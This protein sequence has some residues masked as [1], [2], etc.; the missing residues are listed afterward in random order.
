MNANFSEV[1]E[2]YKELKKPQLKPGS[3]ASLLKL[4]TKIDKYQSKKG[5]LYLQN[6]S[7]EW[8]VVFMKEL[9]N[10]KLGRCTNK[11]LKLYGTL[12]CGFLKHAKMFGYSINNDFDQILRYYQNIKTPKNDKA[13]LKDEELAALYKYK[14]YQLKN[15]AFIKITPA[16]QFGIHLFVFQSQIGFRWGYLARLQRRH[17]QK[18]GNNW[19]IVD[20][21]TQKRGK[22]VSVHLNDLAISILRVYR[23]AFEELSGKTYLFQGSKNC[24][25]PSCGNATHNLK[26]IGKRVG[27]LREVLIV[28]G[29]L[30]KVSKKYVPL[31]TVIATHTARR[32]FA[33]NWIRDGRDIYKLSKILGHSSV[34]TT[35]NY[36]KELKGY[37]PED[38]DTE[39][40][41]SQRALFLL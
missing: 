40:N 16:Q 33:S 39:L 38:I 25:L 5:T 21:E 2:K 9:T 41:T 37:I 3:Y 11:T 27:L 32:T 30:D 4:Q 8:F 20:F 1:F 15:G 23:K 28:Q 36:V 19:Y 35:E 7:L 13:I 24:K 31:Y 34:S 18:K 6:I 29:T 10:G 26:V 14:G 17:L 12:L 22:V